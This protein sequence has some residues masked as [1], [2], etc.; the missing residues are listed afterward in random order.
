MDI[1][2]TCHLQRFY[3]TDEGTSLRASELIPWPLL[4]HVLRVP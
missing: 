1:S 4:S 2:K 3:V